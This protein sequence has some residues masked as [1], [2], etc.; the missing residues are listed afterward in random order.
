MTKTTD[1]RF[2]VPYWRCGK[3]DLLHVYR[4]LKPPPEARCDHCGWWEFHLAEVPV[5][6]EKDT[7]KK[8]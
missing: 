3:C 5:R 7:C 2:K 8:W 6:P 1:T 4:Q